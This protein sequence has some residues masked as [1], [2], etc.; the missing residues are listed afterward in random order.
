MEVQD[1]LRRNDPSAKAPT[2]TEGKNPLKTTTNEEGVE[3]VRIAKG[4]LQ[5]I[6]EDK[7]APAS[8]RA[9]AARTL[10]ELAGAIKNP[11]RSQPLE[12]VIEA[13]SDEIDRRLA[14]LMKLERGSSAEESARRAQ[15]YPAIEQVI[16]MAK[17][18]H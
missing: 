10:L 15:D 5:T 1:M 3:L 17:A 12:T 13:T 11:Q 4:T 6:C 18:K 14:T 8:S 9:A 7:G 2:A 16:A